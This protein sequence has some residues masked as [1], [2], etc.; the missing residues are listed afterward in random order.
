MKH[1]SSKKNFGYK[2][3][4]TLLKDIIYLNPQ[5]YLSPKNPMYLN[6]FDEEKL[7]IDLNCEQINL[8]KMERLGKSIEEE[9]LIYP[10]PVWNNISDQRLQFFGGHLRMRYAAAGGYES[11]DAIILEDTDELGKIL[12]KMG[13]CGLRKRIG[14]DN[15]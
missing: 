10:I 5:R 2:V 7:K 8:V 14:I 1:L 13:T 15:L 4:P 3:Q 11:I 12:E 9:G 6:I